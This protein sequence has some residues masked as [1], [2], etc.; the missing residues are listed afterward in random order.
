MGTRDM[1]K[2]LEGIRKSMFFFNVFPIV[3]GVFVLITYAIP[4]QVRRD[5]SAPGVTFQVIAFTGVAFAMFRTRVSKLKDKHRELYKNEFTNAVLSTI[6]DNA[7]YEWNRGF[8]D[9]EVGTFGIIKMGNMYYSEDY[10]S[11]SYKG[12]KV[13]QADVIIHNEE[14]TD[15]ECTEE[16]CRVTKYFDGRIFEFI[17]NDISVQN[18]KVFSRGYNSWLSIG[19]I[20]VDIDNLLFNDYFD[21]FSL[22]PSEAIEILTNE[23]IEHLLILQNK[24]KSIGIRFGEGKVIVAINGINAFNGDYYTKISYDEECA[25]MKQEVQVIIDLIEGLGLI[26]KE[27]IHEEG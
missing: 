22:E 15:E 25:L 17:A 14:C 23:M 13:R 19:D 12:V 26:K 9:I 3:V 18:V 5:P 10:L 24:Y 27:A 21:V 7:W 6:I 4:L 2:E 16:D 20:R 8:T 11:G 1:V